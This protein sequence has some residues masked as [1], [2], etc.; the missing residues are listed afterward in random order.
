MSRPFGSLLATIM[1][2]PY[3]HRW[4]RARNCIGM[5]LCVA[6][7]AGGPGAASQATAKPGFTVI[8]P[9]RYVSFSLRGTKGFRISLF[10][11]ARQI[12]LE[13]EQPRQQASVVYR[14]R[15]HG[16]RGRVNARFGQLGSIHMHWQP[17]GAFKA[18]SEP[19]GDCQ[20][21][22][23]LFQR[24][25]FVGRFAFRAEGAFTEARATRVRGLKVRSFRNVCRRAGAGSARQPEEALLAVSRQGGRNLRFRASSRASKVGRIEEFEADAAER[26]G[27]L[28]IDRS[29]LTG[30]SAV[31]GEFSFERATGT[32]QV[33]PPNPFVGSGTLNEA[34][35]G[36]DWIGDLVVK[37]PGLGRIALAG[38]GFEAQLTARDGGLAPFGEGLE[39]HRG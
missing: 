5:S 31:Q 23:P 8:P 4:P 33:E 35:T 2:T 21:R 10:A 15:R 1:N 13:A 30:G 22:R 26:I 6:I 16:R 18:S 7:F 17:T 34:M 24:G 11:Y 36:E 12:T 37:L 39:D 19:Q 32:A 25:F 29:V 28:S 14:V 9:G 27:G 38:S 3:L 20:G